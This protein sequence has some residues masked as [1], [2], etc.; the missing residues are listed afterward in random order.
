MV[1]TGST[2]FRKGCIGGEAGRLVARGGLAVAWTCPAAAGCSDSGAAAGVGEVG[3]ASGEFSLSRFVVIAILVTPSFVSQAP[4]GARSR[5]S[6]RGAFRPT[7][8][9][10]FTLIPRNSARR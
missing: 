2:H 9:C 6:K 8:F 3:L 1:T 10:S 5:Q 4:P 7:D